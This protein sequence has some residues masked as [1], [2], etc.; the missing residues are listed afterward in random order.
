MRNIISFSV[1]PFS[2]LISVLLFHHPIPLTV[3]FFFSWFIASLSSSPSFPK[4]TFFLLLFSSLFGPL[5]HLF[6][7]CFCIE[8]KSGTKEKEQE[9]QKRIREEA[10]DVFS[11]ILSVESIG[12][13]VLHTPLMSICYMSFYSPLS[14]SLLSPSLTLL[15]FLSLF[16]WEAI[17][18]RRY[19]EMLSGSSWRWWR[20]LQYENAIIMMTPV[21]S[22]SVASAPHTT[23]KIKRVVMHTS[24]Y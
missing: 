15:P 19:H 9:T 7:C 8:K 14:L 12:S 13:C 23:R 4:R 2:H 16:F 24:R 1:D 18:V 11:S 17:D 6:Q 5:L 20:L 3:S 10:P 21:E 22:S